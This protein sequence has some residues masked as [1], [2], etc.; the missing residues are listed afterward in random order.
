MSAVNDYGITNSESLVVV[1]PTSSGKT[2]I[3]EMAA[4]KAIVEGRK[5]VFLFP[6]KALVNEKYDQFTALYGEQLG[7][8][9]IRCT[10][11]YHDSARLF[12]RGKYDLAVLT[13]EMFLQL[14]L[15]FPA[16]RNQLAL[17]V[18]DEAQFITDPTRGINVELLL[19]FLLAGRELGVCPQ[20]VALSAVIGNANA[21]H[22]WLGCRL[23]MSDARP[24]PLIEGVIDREG[25]LQ[26]VDIDGSTKHDQF[27]PRHEIVQRRDKPSAQDV[28]VPLVRRLVQSGEQVIIFRNQRGFAQGCASYLA[29]DLGLPS[30]VGVIEQLPTGDLSSASLALRECLNHGTAFHTTNL[31]RE[32]R[33]AVEQAFR[34]PSHRVRVLAA[35]TTVAA[36]INTP[37]STVILAEQEFVGEDGRPFTVAEYKNMAGRAGRL[38][39]QEKGKSIIYAETPA[40]RIRLFQKYV[41]GR[42]ESLHSSFDLDH[43]E[44]WV[45]RLLAQVPSIPRSEVVRLLANTYMGFTEN[46]RDLTW[47]PRMT[48]SI[49]QLLD[50]M[51]TLNLLEVEADKVRLTLLGRACGQSA[52][53]FESALRFIELL[54]S[55]PPALVTARNLPAFV[56]VLHEGEV[57]TPML[58]GNKEAIRVGEAIQRY[59]HATID[60]L[61]R[62]AQ[63]MADYWARCKRAAVLFDWMSGVTIDTIESTFSTTPYRGRIELG[64]I[65]RFS[66]S[67]RFILRSASEIVLLIFPDPVLAKGL[68]EMLTQLEVGIPIEMIGFLDINLPLTRGQYIGLYGANIRSVQA[69]WD[70]APETLRKVLPVAMIQKLEKLRPAKAGRGTN[71]E[72]RG[73]QP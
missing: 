53:S 25:V 51:L 41:L 31:N 33:V 48:R 26:Y 43:L 70:T 52:L 10:G 17:V 7:L 66:D 32:E 2:F 60:A 34:N 30:S 73:P 6:Y 36:G 18:V 3:G 4:A 71:E 50:R 55:S 39:F 44:T 69:L 40:E 35:T 46:L 16:L 22:D 54:R 1:A 65:Q 9:I 14:V 64:D 45:L 29:A 21:F 63:T 62:Y 72:P 37:A 67:T 58:A 47:R 68:D 23:L 15:S 49:E 20:I 5:A 27:V 28:I 59:G 61:Q 56:Q 57:Y 42:L 19:T 13:Y 11:D 24:V 38:G 8:R 12:V